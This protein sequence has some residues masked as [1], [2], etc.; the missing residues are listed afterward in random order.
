MTVV[1]K[2]GD[3]FSHSS[4]KHQHTCIGHGVNSAGAMGAGIAVEFKKRYP[5]MFQEYRNRCYSGLIFPGITWAWRELEGTFITKQEIL[6]EDCI[7]IYNLAIKAHWKLDATYEAI[8]GSLKNMAIHMNENSLKEV[9]LPWIGCGLGGLEK[10]KVKTI[11]EKIS[12]EYKINIIVY[13]N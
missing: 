4:S 3:L 9:G 1:I 5:E 10:T 6:G 11:M 7:W 2:K 8:E 13:E 12:E